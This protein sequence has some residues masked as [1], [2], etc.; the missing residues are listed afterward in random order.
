MKKESLNGKWTGSY[1]LAEA[2]P[3]VFDGQVPGCAHTDLLRC[4]LL[5]DY[6]KGYAVEE[7]R[8][9]ER[10]RFTYERDFDFQGEAEGVQLVFTGLDTFCDVFL[11][12]R[13]LGSCDDMFLPYVFEVSDCLTQGRN[14]IEVRFYPPAERVADRPSY[15]AAFTNE[16]VHIRRMQCTFGWDWVDRF[17]TMGIIGDVWLQKPSATEIDSLYA[18]TTQIDAQGAEVYVRADFAPKGSGARL[19]WEIRDPQ[20]Q[21]VWSQRRRVTEEAVVE[22]VAIEEPQLWWPAGYGGQPLYRL[23][24]RVTGEDG[25]QLSERET[26]FGLRTLR[27]VEKADRPGTPEYELA[28][29]L[30]SQPRLKELDQNEDYAGYTVL[31]NGTKIFCKGANWVPCEPFPSDAAPEKYRRLLRLA[32]EAHVTMLR[33]W[34]GG[35]FEKDV[36]YDE[37]D[38]LGIL[39]IQDLLM[40]CGEYPEDQGW[41]L[42][43]LRRE[44]ACAAKRLRSHPSLA[45]WNGDNENAARCDLDMTEYPGRRAAMETAAPVLRE[46]D[47][48]RRFTPT[49]P[50]GG[51]PFVSVT[52][53]TTHN[54]FFIDWMFEQ[55]RYGDLSNYHQMFDGLLSRF[56][57]ELPCMGTPALTSLRRFLEGDQVYDDDCLRFHTKNNPCP[58][59]ADFGIYDA[60]VAFAGKLLG[61]FR[62][63]DDKLLK[64]QYI[65]YEWVRYC[66]ELYR[67]HKWFSSGA[68]FWMFND[69]WPANGWALVDYYGVPKAGYYALKNTCQPVAASIAAAEGG[70]AVYVLNDLPET[71]EGETRLYVQGMTERTPLWEKTISFRVGANLSTAVWKG[72]VPLPETG[73]VLLCDLRT[74]QGSARTFY[75]PKRVRDIGLPGRPAEVV[76]RT[77]THITLQAPAYIH[78]V[79]LD[80][81]YDFED[82][83]FPLTPGERRTIALRATGEGDSKDIMVRCL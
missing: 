77:D 16:R 33:V 44:A 9:V 12:G 3:V 74:R 18:A 55:F 45:W 2:S 42:D 5:P 52:K 59:F 20:D 66:V 71:V 75:F 19:E 38:R 40:A 79:G 78:A 34:G 64:L 69:C 83:F 60:Q 39:V 13:K 32:A 41:F 63:R 56:N 35:L 68:L 49:S 31:V 17:V 50:Y 30:Q 43:R 22:R 81:A 54:T 28:K 47:P 21:V 15:P 27:V 46:M 62:D 29:R 10:A 6:K 11:N 80:G 51:K 23:C 8:F 4:G 73:A 48:F 26:A 67:R 57:S 65:Q 24:A 36:F 82:N 25:A 7:C 37:C 76:E 53:G 72:E 70:F 58:E 1:V 14:H 61:E